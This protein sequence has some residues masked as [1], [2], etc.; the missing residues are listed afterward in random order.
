MDS[1]PSEFY[2]GVTVLGAAINLFFLLVPYGLF[3]SLI[4]WCPAGL[5][6]NPYSPSMLVVQQFFSSPQKISEHVLKPLR[7]SVF[8]CEGST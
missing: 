2:R 8:L 3:F 6:R 7:W 4:R 5:R 1:A